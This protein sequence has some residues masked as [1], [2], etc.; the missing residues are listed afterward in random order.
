MDWIRI[1]NAAL[2]ID[3]ISTKLADTKISRVEISL[4][5]SFKKRGFRVQL[6]NGALKGE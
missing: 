1:T 3:Y 5:L 4:D 2:P 6:L